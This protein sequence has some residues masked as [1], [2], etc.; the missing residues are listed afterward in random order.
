MIETLKN[1]IIFVVA[2]III[3]GIGVFWL[4]FRLDGDQ[5]DGTGIINQPSQFAEVRAEILRTIATLQA[6][7]LDVS[8]LDDPAFQ[9]LTEAPQPLEGVPFSGGRRNPFAP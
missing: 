3:I 7:R 4:F 6:V 8:V 5:Q 2:I 1:N 9:A